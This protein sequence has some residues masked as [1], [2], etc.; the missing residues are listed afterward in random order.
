LGGESPNPVA[1]GTESSGGSEL[2]LPVNA[3]QGVLK[4]RRLTRGGYAGELAISVIVGRAGYI[5][6]FV[7]F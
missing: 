2:V 4:E 1:A 3:A 7:Y 5:F 6:R